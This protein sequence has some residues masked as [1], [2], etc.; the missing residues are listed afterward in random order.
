MPLLVR[1]FW[2]PRA[3][4]DS[5]A[6]EDAFAV[7]PGW[8]FAAAVADGATE[9]AFAGSWARYLVQSFCRELPLTPGT[10]QD[11]LS[12]WRT[13]WT[14]TL[15]TASLPWYL[16]VKLDEG[17]CATLL[18][19][20]LYADGNWQ[21]LAVGDAVLFHLRQVQLL[22]AWPLSHAG[23]FTQRPS[24]ISSRAEASPAAVDIISGG[25]KPGDAFIL[26]TDALAAWLLRTDPTLPLRLTSAELAT[27]V[28]AARQQRS[29]RNDD[30]TAVVILG[31][32]P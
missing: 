1:T 14:A 21:A 2:L 29:L 16:A 6:Y 28:Q 12:R 17:A 23:Q 32:E 27:R 11:S 5:V 7:Q 24:L 3:P 13:D 22:Q 10:F 4:A 26:A 18:G 19:M 30:V 25:W 20:V 15:P 31:L 9:T 8:P